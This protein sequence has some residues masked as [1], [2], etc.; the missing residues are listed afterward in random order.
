MNDFPY[1][2]PIPTSFFLNIPKG[3]RCFMHDGKRKNKSS[4]KIIRSNKQD[5]RVHKG[6]RS[7]G[8]QSPRCSY[9]SRHFRFFKDTA[10]RSRDIVWVGTTTCFVQNL[11]LTTWQRGIVDVWVAG[12]KLLRFLVWHQLIFLLMIETWRIGA[13]W[14]MNACHV[15]L[16]VVVPWVQSYRKQKQRHLKK[17]L[18]I[19]Q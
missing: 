19:P 8:C 16:L 15:T 13:I 17:F 5:W 12:R 14:S 7:W 18:P 1:L 4:R 11:H 10:M 3:S 2:V 9:P 6:I